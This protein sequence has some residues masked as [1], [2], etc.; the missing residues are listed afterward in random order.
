MHP[1]LISNRL[2]PLPSPLPL[3]T[4]LR[5]RLT[6][7]QLK[8]HLHEEDRVRPDGGFGLCAPIRPDASRNS[9][10]DLRPPEPR[11]ARRYGSCRLRSSFMLLIYGIKDS[12]L[13]L[14]LVNNSR[15]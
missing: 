15:E 8:L 11:G 7:V 10:S 9:A 1:P 2:Y 13:D 14:C 12:N 4:P 6:V 3:K 5:S